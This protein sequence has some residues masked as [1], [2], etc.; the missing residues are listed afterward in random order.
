[1]QNRGNRHNY[2]FAISRICLQTQINFADVHIHTRLVEQQ[3][4]LLRIKLGLDDRTKKKDFGKKR[5]LN[6]NKKAISNGFKKE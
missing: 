1:M 4:F 2:W 5:R 3:G 6:R